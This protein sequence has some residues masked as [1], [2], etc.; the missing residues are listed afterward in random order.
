[1]NRMVTC[2]FMPLLMLAV[3]GLV[4]ANPQIQHWTTANGAQ[5]YFVPAHEIPMVDVRVVFDAAA[6]RDGDKP[7][8]AKLSI[9]M[10]NEGAGGLT[11]TQ[12]TERLDDLGAQLGLQSLR[13][14]AYI[15]IR[16]LADPD[17]LKPAIDTVAMMIRQ[18]DFPPDAFERVRKQMLI[19]LRYAQQRASS[20]ANDI[21]FATLYGDH[22]YAHPDDGTVES[23]SAITPDDARAFHARYLVAANA[24]LAIVGD[25]DRA[26]AEA[27]AERIIGGLPEGDKPAPLPDVP[28]A[29]PAPALAPATTRTIHLPHPGQQ[30][31]IVIG[32]PVAKRGDPDWFPL[33]VGNQIL[34][35][36]G[37]TSRLADEVRE[38]RGLAYSASSGFS[39]MRAAGPFVL[40][41]QTRNDQTN[42]AV[43]VIRDTLDRFI[44]DGPSEQELDAVKKNLRG[45][46]PLRIASNAKIL[47]YIAMIGFYGLPLD[48]LDQFDGKV[49]AVTVDSVRDAFTRRVDPAHMLT[50]LVGGEADAAR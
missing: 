48:Y 27:L 7:G 41:A 45:G 49:A 2:V 47:D 17:I 29:A 6:S 35:G 46:F 13:D 38:Q 11:A 32:Q 44:A 1:M 50:V 18:P 10:L 28:A 37:L 40:G 5:V 12:L 34:G 16:S 3:S 25:L 30:T 43:Q 15:Q 42:E 9:G 24:T 33:Y 39:P 14:M 31:H 36:A 19:G 23:L 4:Q 21:L 22:P 26:A 20:R 8:L